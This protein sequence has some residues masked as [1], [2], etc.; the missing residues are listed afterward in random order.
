MW[1]YVARRCLLAIPTLWGATLIVFILMRVAPGD[2][3]IMMLGG[4]EGGE[5]SPEQ[6]AKVRAQFGLD[7][8]MHIQYVVW[9]GGML[10][11]DFGDSFW[12]RIP[13]IDLFRRKWPISLQVGLMLISISASIAIPF[14]ILSALYQDRWPD[15]VLRSFAFAFNSL[16][17]FWFG[18]MTI[19]FLI[20]VFDWI[21]EQGYIPI[22]ERPGANMAQLIW[23]AVVLGL[24]TASTPLRMMRSTMLEVLRE[25]YIRTARSKGLTERIII[26]RHA[27]RNALIPV[28]TLY[29]LQIPIAVGGLVVTEQVFGIPG[30]GLMLVNSITQRDYPVTQMMV[31]LIAVTVVMSNLLVDLMYGWLDPRIRY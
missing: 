6:L 30:V 3:A 31:A 19:L 22:W 10:K 4:E 5:V 24:A 7:K 20:R 18:L 1:G 14:G 25:D 27:M 17:T 23:P 13:T 8:P 21:P 12:Y 29:G 16:P 15:Y 26:V 11:G 9:M 2:V 28:V